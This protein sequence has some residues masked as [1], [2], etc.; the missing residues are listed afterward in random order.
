LTKNQFMF[1]YLITS[2]IAISLLFQLDSNFNEA[3]VKKEIE[4]IDKCAFTDTIFHKVNAQH[5]TMTDFHCSLYFLDSN[6]MKINVFGIY[7]NL[8][9]LRTYYFEETDI[10][11]V[12]S[13]SF[14]YKNY[15]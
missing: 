13:Q 11:A 10:F 9:Y 7:P 4:R 1:N 2:V 6:L 3:P 12:V 14:N 8:L 15:T 5:Y